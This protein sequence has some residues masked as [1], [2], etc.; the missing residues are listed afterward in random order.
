MDVKMTV[1]TK[2]KSEETTAKNESKSPNRVKIAAP[3]SYIEVK[4]KNKTIII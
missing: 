3:M 1:I 4:N 2:S